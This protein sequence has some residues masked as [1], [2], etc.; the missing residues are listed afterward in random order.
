MASSS[1]SSSSSSIPRPL[2]DPPGWSSDPNLRPSSTPS[3]AYDW[4][5][6]R[7]PSSSSSHNPTK[8]GKFLLFRSSD[9][10][11]TTW[12]TI[13]SGVA[14]GDVWMAKVSTKQLSQAHVICLYSPDYED[15][16]DILRLL[17]WIERNK[18]KGPNQ[19]IAY[20]TDLATRAGVYGVGSS[21]Y[22]SKKLREKFP[23]NENQSNNKENG[24]QLSIKQSFKLFQHEK[25]SGQRSVMEAAQHK[26]SQEKHLNSPS[27]EHSSHNKRNEFEQL[28]DEQF[29]RDLEFATRESLKLKNQTIERP[30]IGEW[31]NLKMKKRKEVEENENNQQV[32]RETN[33]EKKFD[34]G[35]RRVDSNP[36]RKEIVLD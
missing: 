3:T 5:Y 6:A 21:L 31:K 36:R 1:P 33:Q 7:L 22:T 27:L 13:R 9:C 4:L 12:D 30:R 25:E 18:L 23:T 32:N 8:V 16:N 35:E 34:I 11:D 24:K 14:S 20:K 15:L 17:S 26:K 29:T 2:L 10:V 19:T 28:D